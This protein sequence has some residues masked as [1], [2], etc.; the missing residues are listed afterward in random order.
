[1][2]LLGCLA[3]LA[4]LLAGCGARGASV[5]AGSATAAGAARALQE[6]RIVDSQPGISFAPLYVAL[7]KGYFQEVG[8]RPSYSKFT[9]GQSVATVIGSDQA[10]IVAGS[11]GAGNFTAINR[12]IEFRIVSSLA[13]TPATG[14]LS[15]LMVRK[16]L[17]DNGQVKTVAD[18]KRRKLALFGRTGAPGYNAALILHEAGLTFEDLDVLNLSWPDSVLALHNGAVEAAYLPAPFTTEIIRQGTG[19]MIAWPNEIGRSASATLY[20]HKFIAERPDAAKAA[21]V[22]LVRG[23]R[24]VQQNPKSDE[25]LAIYNK[26][27]QLPGETMRAMDM[28]DFER[29]LTPDVDTILDMQRLFM[30]DGQITYTSPLPIE[31]LVDASFTGY[32]KVQLG[33]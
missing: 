6:V 20:S 7:E 9:D 29:D 25:N 4:L 17:L 32:A 1:M 26:Y 5:T 15:G 19:G 33:P 14:H 16:D 21:M 2:R 12:G 18:L 3:L 27:I 10:D 11:G 22:A 30:A 13:M 31:R 28:P 23:A 8:L 24:A